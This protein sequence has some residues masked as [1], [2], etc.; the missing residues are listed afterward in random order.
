MSQKTEE[1]Q[2]FSQGEKFLKSGKFD[3]AEAAFANAI[4]LNEANPVNWARLG[5]VWINMNRFAE[6]KDASTMALQLDPANHD[7]L[8]NMAR[9]H[10]ALDDSATGL[11][12][13]EKL[14]S[15]N[16]DVQLAEMLAERYGQ[17]S[18]FAKSAYYYNEA[19]KINPANQELKRQLGM[20][21]FRGK[22]ITNALIVFVDLVLQNPDNR[23][24]IAVLVEIY[25]KIRHEVYSDF[26]RK[27]LLIC[28]ETDSVN[29]RSVGMP[30]C[31]IILL[32]PALKGWR[33]FSYEKL[34]DFPALFKDELLIQGLRK[35]SILDVAL[36][37]IL[38]EIRKTFLLHY[39][40]FKS[41][42]EEILTFLAA[43]AEQCWY[44]DFVFYRTEEEISS[45]KKLKEFLS[46]QINR[47]EELDAISA[48]FALYACYEPL[49]P[50][51][52][53]QKKAPF[54]KSGFY[55]LKSLYKAQVVNPA[56][57]H[58]SWANIPSFT[59]IT[60]QTSR[61]VQSMYEQRPYPKW[62][63]LD[64]YNNHQQAK[65]ISNGLKILVA[66]CGTG[67]EPAQYANLLRNAHITAVDLSRASLAY[68]KRMAETTGFSNRIDFWH[69]DLMEIGRLNRKF[70]LVLSSGVLHHLKDPL[71]G[72]AAIL[73]TMK[74]DGRIG[75]SLYSQ[76]ARDYLLGPAEDYIKEKAY[77][78][79]D[80]DIR[81][82]RHDIM[83]MSDDD[84]RRRCSTVGDF[85]YLAE[86][87][88]LLFHIQEHRYTFPMIEE[89][90]RQMDLIPI[91][92]QLGSMR[93]KFKAMHPD[94]GSELDFD[95]LHSFEQENPTA[96]IGM[97][98]VFFRRMHESAFMPIDD[99]I[100]QGLI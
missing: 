30:W 87:N 21:F 78:A 26:F 44:N 15:M 52:G 22:D 12:Y 63:S 91:Y 3:Q 43:L 37:K 20:T 57:E 48:L 17:Q 6:A 93:D 79:S 11:A 81:H 9:I 27:A 18:N 64:T 14:F 100:T 72:L 56:K 89:L 95:R 99:L 31:S 39:T 92:V 71:K 86:C 61:A 96:F 13:W 97:Y 1:I 41:W 70:D 74:P 94:E 67:R 2:A 10:F 47:G 58:E 80:D 23:S 51:F 35:T 68:A 7:A 34:N 60:D 55:H 98:R 65:S 88:D 75:I 84:P 33:E 90:A 49:G 54:S 76:I 38:T 36:E 32:D 40:D 83:V 50:L 85:F 66:G 19:L 69:G 4:A 8:D 46:E 59:E 28:L 29:H 42:P 82:F 62:L 77:T 53:D 24:Y 73:D 16:H 5:Q 25:R 45:L